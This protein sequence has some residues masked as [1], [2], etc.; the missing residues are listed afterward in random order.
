VQ[1]DKE[2]VY[3]K[4]RSG[5]LFEEVND[6]RVLK[7]ALG[8]LGRWGKCHSEEKRERCAGVGENPEFPGRW[9]PRGALGGRRTKIRKKWRGG[10]QRTKGSD[11]GEGKGGMIQLTAVGTE[12]RSLAQG[13]GRA[14]KRNGTG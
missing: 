8:M 12:N 2:S 14:T 6:T 1:G 5:G 9:A 13:R 10:R 4:H 7:G 3:W 11:G